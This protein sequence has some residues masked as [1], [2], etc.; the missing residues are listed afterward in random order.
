MRTG[1]VGGARVLPRARAL[2]ARGGLSDLR[3]CAISSFFFQRVQSCPA[4]SRPPSVTSVWEAVWGARAFQSA[5]AGVLRSLGRALL[6]VF[7]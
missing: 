1:G 6:R 2:G 3:V 7:S 4:G 5:L